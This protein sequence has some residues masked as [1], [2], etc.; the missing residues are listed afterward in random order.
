MKIKEIM[1]ESVIFFSPEDSIYEVA[2]KLRESR[3][4]GAPVLEGDRI[5]GV[6]SEADIMKLV[7]KEEIELNTFL[8]SPFDVLELPIRMKLNLDRIMKKI[9]KTGEMKVKNVMT[10]KVITINQ[11]EDVSKAA[12]V[13]REAG[14]NRLPVVNQE[15]KLVGILTRG[16][17][18]KAL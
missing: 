10:R 12:S 11:E 17:L 2:K 6:I 4:S 15:G 18:L 3:I 9:Q 13:M 14:I 1:T 5:E 8:P 7:E 16:D